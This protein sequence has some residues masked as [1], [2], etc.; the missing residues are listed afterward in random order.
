M[1]RGSNG[2][3][4]ALSADD[5][6][7]LRAHLR[8]VDL[9]HE[10]VL[11]ETGET[12]RRA[13]FPHRGVISLVVKLAK[14]EHVQV[15]MIG[16]DSLLGTLSIMGDAC[17]LSTAIVLVAGVAS[18]MDLDRLRAAADQSSTLRTLLARHGLAV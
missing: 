7:L 11:V 4:S 3:L 15:G 16:R 9:P 2:F 1:G 8:T 6:E 14:G 17:A 13:Y 12:L 5:Y 10:A 18:V